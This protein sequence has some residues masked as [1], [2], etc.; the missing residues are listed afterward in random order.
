MSGQT[1]Q[2]RSKEERSRTALASA[3]VEWSPYIF[4]SHFMDTDL[5][6]GDIIGQ[7]DYCATTLDLDFVKAMPNGVYCAEDWGAVA[8]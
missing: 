3:E 2:V 5:D 4:W 8:E 6:A 7:A 1:G